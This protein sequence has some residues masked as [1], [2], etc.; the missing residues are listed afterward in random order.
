M[1]VLII[2][3]LKIDLQVGAIFKMQK[4]V[5]KSVFNLSINGWWVS[6]ENLPKKNTEL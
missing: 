6:K 3:R 1:G 2:T 4:K 5:L